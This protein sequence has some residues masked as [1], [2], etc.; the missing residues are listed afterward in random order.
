V[1]TTAAWATWRPGKG[2]RSLIITDDDDG[3]SEPLALIPL[4]G[5]RGGRPTP[6]V[7]D[8]LLATLGYTRTSPWSESLAHDMCADVEPI[9]PGSGPGGQS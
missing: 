3:H 6:A 4:P 1:T 2:E 5:F 7:L 9:R 8:D